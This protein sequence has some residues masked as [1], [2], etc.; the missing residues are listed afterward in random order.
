MLKNAA[1]RRDPVR[2]TRRSG[3]WS[4]EFT[5]LVKVDEHLM[6]PERCHVPATSENLRRVAPSCPPTR[7]REAEALMTQGDDGGDCVFEL[8]GQGWAP[9]PQR[10]P[11]GASPGVRELTATVSDL[12]SQLLVMRGLHAALLARV[13]TIEALLPQKAP[14]TP[15]PVPVRREPVNTGPRRVPSRRDMMALLQPSRELKLDLT[16]EALREAQGPESPSAATAVRAEAG[17]DAPGLAL[18]ARSDVTQCLEL[19]AA[20]VTLGSEDLEQ[21][22]D[23]SSF[24]MA[25]LVDAAEDTLAVILLEQHAG[26]ALGGALLGLPLPAREQQAERGLAEDTFEALNEICNNLGGLIKRANPRLTATLRPLKRWDRGTVPWL[27]SAR[28]TLD[29]S[30][31]G[32]G[33]LR[34]AAR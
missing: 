6:R 32:G 29:F 8:A 15:E 22:A 12:Q 26:A 24:Y 19:L 34:I 25:R 7:L 9:V 23:A 30:T 16:L 11:P 27:E 21:L 28:K 18:P 1:P 10:T 31:P 13:V 4:L 5:R 14:V 20:D 3:T 17:A 33:M 2:L